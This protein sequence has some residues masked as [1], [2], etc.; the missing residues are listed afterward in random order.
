MP[1]ETLEIEHKQHPQNPRIFSLVAYT[2]Q[3]RCGY[4]TYTLEGKCVSLEDVRVLTPRHGIGR[5]LLQEFVRLIG[6]GRF[7]TAVVTHQESLDYLKSLGLLNQATSQ[8]VN[9]TEQKPLSAI[10]IVQ[11]LRSG[12]ILASRLAISYVDNPDRSSVPLLHVEFNGITPEQQ[13]K[14]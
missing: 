2:D 13:S 11:F 14:V 7:I 1:L 6:F 9:I 8:P 4:L 10:P 3:K 12:G 5:A